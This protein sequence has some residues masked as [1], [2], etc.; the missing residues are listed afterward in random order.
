MMLNQLFISAGKSRLLPLFQLKRLLLL[1]PLIICSLQSAAQQDIELADYYYENGQYEQAR[2][3]YDKVYKSNKTNKVYTNY[4]NTLIAL[5][6][7]EEAEKLVKKKIKTENDDGTAYVQLGDLYNK[8]NKKEEAKAQFEKAISSYVPT[9]NNTLKLAG[10][11]TRINEHGYALKT[12]EKGRKNNSEGYSYSFEM[13]NVLGNLGR[14]DEM[15]EALLDLILES[16]NY[17]QT[18]QN[19]FERNL[20]LQENFENQELLKGKLLKRNQKYPEN[21]E[22]SEMLIWLFMQKKEFG[23]ALTQVIALDKRLSESGYRVYTLAELAAGNKEYSTAKKALDYLIT[24]GPQGEYYFM[25]RTEKLQ[26]MNQELNESPTF[27]KAAYEALATEYEIAISELGKKIETATM[28]KDLAHI[29]AF[30]IDKSDAAVE[31]LNETLEIPGLYGKVQAAVKLELADVYVFRNEIWDASL[32]YSQVELDFKEDPLGAEARYRNARISYFTGDFEWAQGQLDALKASTTKL[33]SNDAIDL[34]LVITD[35]FNMDTI[36]TP[37]EM[38]ARADLLFYQNKFELVLQTL[39]SISKEYPAHSLTDEILM[40][41]AKMAKRQGN[42][43]LAVELYTKVV[44]FHFKDITADNALFELAEIHE[45]ILM[46]STKA[47]TYYE[48]LITEYPG[49]LFVVE[50]R[51]RFRSLRGDQIE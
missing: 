43:P 3:Y 15:I 23:L 12:Y 31:L 22:Y 25:A 39:D 50:A 24:K 18:V 9:R 46:D 28:L 8:F 2:L 32:L 11:F 42:I 17:L 27:N 13:A 16:P 49:S 7:F 33:I 6:D 37:M 35:N 38:Y 1:L 36:T 10:E 19:S 20:Q 48:K 4:L 29:Y 41:R 34:S 47:M 14:F 30:Y 40:M 5:N 21:V 26:V 51:K 45:K 44:E